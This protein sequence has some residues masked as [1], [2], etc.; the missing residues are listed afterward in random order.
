MKSCGWNCP[1]AAPVV[2]A[3][4]FQRGGSFSVRSTSAATPSRMGFHRHR[5]HSVMLSPGRVACH[6]RRQTRASAAAGD[7]IR[8]TGRSDR[9]LKRVQVVYGV[10]FALR[11]PGRD[12]GQ[13]CRESLRHLAVGE[14]AEVRQHNLF[15]LQRRECR[16]GID[17]LKGVHPGDEGTGVIGMSPGGGGP[18]SGASGP[19]A[20]SSL[21]PG[22][23]T[24]L[25]TTADTRCAVRWRNSV[26]ASWLPSRFAAA[27][28][29]GRPR[30]LP[31]GG[32]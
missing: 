7:G 4:D 15:A 8:R 31:W 21:S 28:R 12:G 10:F 6:S 2:R 27:T 3:A 11:G 17:E 14:G 26:K 19:C 20:T 9:A 1:G 29:P 13:R 22:S 23:I 5:N 18:R 32:A 25:R 30:G 16:Q 24:T